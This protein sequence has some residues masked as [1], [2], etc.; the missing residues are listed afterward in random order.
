VASAAPEES[1]HEV[2]AAD[3]AADDGGAGA[4]CD[5]PLFCWTDED[6]EVGCGCIACRHPG[7]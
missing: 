1:I 3:A 5:S 4:A 7:G 6:V 2:L